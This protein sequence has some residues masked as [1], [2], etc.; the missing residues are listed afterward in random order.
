[1]EELV[2]V[3]CKNC[4]FAHHDFDDELYCLQEVGSAIRDEYIKGVRRKDRELFLL[5]R[6]WSIPEE[7]TGCMMW[8]PK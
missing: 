4:M 5:K 7:Q 6:A 3:K 1:M 2:R 8:E